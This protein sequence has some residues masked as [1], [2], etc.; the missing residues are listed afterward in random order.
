MTVRLNRTTSNNPNTPVYKI[1]FT[2]ED[3]GQTPAIVEVAEPP[4]FVIP[5]SVEPDKELVVLAH[6]IEKI[7]VQELAIL[8]GNYGR[9]RVFDVLLLAKEETE[10]GNKIRSLTAYLH[11]AI[12]NNSASG[13]SQLGKQ[14]RQDTAQLKT[15]QDIE[16]A[17]K[18]GFDEFKTHYFLELG[19]QAPKDKKDA[20]F[21]AIQDEIAH[22]PALRKIYHD[23]NDWLPDNLRMGLGAKLNTK[24]DD[25]LAALY[26][27]S[28]GHP[29]Q[30]IKNFWAY[31]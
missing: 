21:Q 13:K 23:G 10:K 11:N 29:I 12:R 8:I 18:R 26:M 17:I 28:V 5:L 27:E 15:H 4:Q 2:I 7:D 30:R 16:K 3:N 25:Q 1:A 31:V 19:T 6:Q 22:K 9:D 14:K 20:F 24:T